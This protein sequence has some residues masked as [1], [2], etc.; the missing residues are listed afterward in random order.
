[1]TLK[2]IHKNNT[3]AGQAPAPSDL[4]IG[5]IA[6]NSADAQLYV[7]DNDGAIQS[8]TNDNDAVT[9]QQ[10]TQAGSNAVPRTVE[11]KLRDAV[12]VKDFGAVGDGVT[13]DSAAFRAAFAASQGVYVPAGEYFFDGDPIT[14]IKTEDTPQSATDRAFYLYG[15]GAPNSR[16]V[17]ASGRTFMDVANNIRACHVRDIAFYDFEHCF[18]FTSTSV[19]VSNRK[20][21]EYC[22]FEGYTGCAISQQHQDSPYWSIENCTFK[23]DQL[24]NTSMG[25]ALGDNPNLS[26]IRDNAF[27]RNR[28]HLKLGGGGVDVLVDH[29][30]FLQF[31]EAGDDPRCSVFIVTNPPKGA[32]QNFTFQN[33]KLGNENLASGDYRIII[34]NE[35]TGTFNGDRFPDLSNP[36]TAGDPLQGMRFISNKLQGAGD[37]PRSFIYTFSDRLTDILIDDLTVTASNQIPYLI[38]FD[39]SLIPLSQRNYE[40]RFFIGAIYG[41][42]YQQTGKSPSISNGIVQ[43]T[44]ISSDDN[45]EIVPQAYSNN[46]SGLGSNRTGYY[47]INA[48]PVGSFTTGGVASKSANI[49]DSTGESNAATFNLSSGLCYP[50][51]SSSNLPGNTNGALGDPVW[52]HF[53]LKQST[54][55]PITMASVGLRYSGNGAYIERRIIQVPV[56]WTQFRFP[57]YILDNASNLL[58]EFKRFDTSGNNLDIGRSYIYSS[59][60][61]VPHGKVSF[62]S[63]DTDSIH[64][65]SASVGGTSSSPNIALNSDGS[66]TYSGSVSIGGTGAVNTIDVYEEGNWNPAIEVGGVQLNITGRE[67]S[68]V[69]VGTLVTCCGF[70]NTTGAALESGNVT[71]TGLPVLP[72]SGM[73][74]PGVI[75]FTN[76]SSGATITDNSWVV[77]ATGGSTTLAIVNQDNQSITNSNFSGSASQKFRFSITYTAGT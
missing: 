41:K 46:Y 76:L 25:V 26:T 49:T 19:N 5:E 3:S 70:V 50:T 56:N 44:Y 73:L 30:D 68:Y 22:L 20:M 61:P 53:E 59:K 12:S 4:D 42:D 10:I 37:N 64:T 67:A 1:M 32:G 13:D 48:T 54:T 33:N 65:D 34:A 74:V 72:E 23:A 62:D 77:L 35:K 9:V 14:V 52:V 55:D 45:L 39:Q 27:I 38:E 24:S 16:I 29:N 43:I 60:D 71:I 69:R 15:D 11:S 51:I 17:M 7:K 18:K 28:V 40:L 8:F 36:S 21:W 2:L 31:S 66:A 57:V 58:L 47:L 75:A 6:V 63:V